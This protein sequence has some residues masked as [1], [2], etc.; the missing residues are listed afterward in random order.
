MTAKP[1]KKDS[2]QRLLAQVTG[3][4][5]VRAK[6]EQEVWPLDGL[7]VL[8]VGGRAADVQEVR[9]MLEEWGASVVSV[10]TVGAGLDALSLS[11]PGAV[12]VAKEQCDGLNAIRVARALHFMAVAP[13]LIILG[14][15][16]PETLPPEWHFLSPTHD[17]TDLLALLKKKD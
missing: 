15:R 14:E 12:V 3:A 11:R 17:P 9:G 8:W 16:P 10:A 4:S 5:G 6:T 13:P 7:T 2:V 1:S